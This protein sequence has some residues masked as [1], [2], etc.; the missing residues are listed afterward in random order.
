MITDQISFYDGYVVNFGI[1][2]DVIA[3]SYENKE[4]VKLRCIDAIKNYFKIDSMQFK[5]V[6]YTNDVRQVLMDVD[7]VRGVN[8]VTITQDKDYNSQTAGYGTEP[9]IF[10]PGLYTTL[11]K[12][13]GTTTTTSNS[14]Y[15]YY[16]DFSQFYG[17]KSVSGDGIVLPAYEPAVFELKNPNENIVGVVR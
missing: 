4:E 10:N 16:Y 9:S 12:S 3:Q 15:G 8:Y 6:L 5:Q 11:I 14:G 1:V 17:S 7:G 2:F 13:D